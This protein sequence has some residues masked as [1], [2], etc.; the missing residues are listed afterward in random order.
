MSGF[1][2]STDSILRELS[3]HS[4]DIYTTTLETIL[5]SERKV[6]NDILLIYL[7]ENSFENVPSESIDYAVMEKTSQ[8]A[9]IPCDIGWSDIGDWETLG[10]F[11]TP[12]E[13]GNRLRGK[14]IF[15]ESKNCI[16]R[17]NERLISL[18]GVEDLIVIDTDDAL[19][20]VKRDQTQKVKDIY[21]QLDG[22][23]ILS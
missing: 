16:V 17:G 8:I 3:I 6:K 12:D 1:C 9:V 18:I 15:L 23:N 13:N 21:S 14:T 19:L 4:Y 5:K 7:D 22:D 10:T 11:D 2:F 20:I